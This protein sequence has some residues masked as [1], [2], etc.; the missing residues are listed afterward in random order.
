MEL[1]NSYGIDANVVECPLLFYDIQPFVLPE[2]AEEPISDDCAI[3]ARI[4]GPNH[5]V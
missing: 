1:G 3:L 4:V 5:L 2:P